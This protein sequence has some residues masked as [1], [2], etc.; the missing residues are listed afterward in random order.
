MAQQK[1]KS[2]AAAA[3]AAF[4]VSAALAPMASA[5]DNPFQATELK[6]GY[7]LAEHHGEGH[8]G[9]AGKDKRDKDRKAKKDKEGK[10]GEGRCG[11]DKETDENPDR[12]G[13]PTP[14]G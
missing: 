6:S 12:N 3:G 1:T 10:C 11:G 14:A 7:E 9:D 8:N 4:L 5:A 2:L 13:G